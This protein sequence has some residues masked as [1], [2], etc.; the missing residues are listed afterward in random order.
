MDKP[1][2]TVEEQVAL[3]ESRGMATDSNTPDILLREGYY[4]VVN[5]Y[6]APFI[7]RDASAAAKDDRYL[8]GSKFEDVYSLFRFD[9]ELRLLLFGRFSIAEETLKT[10]AAYCFSKVHAGQH[11]PYLDPANYDAETHQVARLISDFETALGRNPRRQ[12]K[13]KLYLD[14]Y[15]SNHDEVPIWVIMKYIT[16]GQAF[17]FYCFQ[18]ES[19]RNDVAKTF[20]TLYAN[21]HAKPILIT[22]RR[23]RLAYDHIKDFRNICAHDERLYCAR[24][25]P[26]LDT[27]IGDVVKDLQLVLSKAEYVNF[28]TEYLRMMPALAKDISPEVMNQVLNDMKMSPVGE[29]FLVNE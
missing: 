20:S 27:A 23:L 9:R 15:V 7:D 21:C 29:A 16:L 10:V 8:P 24:V 12:P 19:V 1:F 13:R 4:S 28:L 17:K 18:P 22:Q 14:H 11:E 2:K 25:A 5:G 6:K 3:L 26:S